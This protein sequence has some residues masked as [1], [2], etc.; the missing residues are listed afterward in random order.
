MFELRVR[1]L[2]HIKANNVSPSVYRRL[3][4]VHG[5]QRENEGL[6]VLSLHI[7]RNKSVSLSV[8]RRLSAVH[9]EQRENEGLGVLSL[10]IPRRQ[11]HLVPRHL[12]RVRGVPWK[13]EHRQ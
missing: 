9:G 7:P 11:S 1:V 2:S 8:Y 5:E 13:I 6:G 3:F 10:H 12:L 4:A